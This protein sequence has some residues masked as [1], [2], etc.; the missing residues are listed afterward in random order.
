LTESFSA[1][2][3]I[4]RRPETVFVEGTGS[5]LTDSAGARYLGFVQGW[6]VNT[7]GHGHPAILDAIRH[8]AERLINP[9]QIFYNQPMIELA[10][11][12]VAHSAF[13]QVFFANSGAEANE[14]AVK[15]ARKWGSLHRGGAYKIITFE[16]AFHGRTLAMMSASGK[17]GWDSLFAPKVPGFTR[18]PFN[19]VRAVADA[20]D[21]DTVAV[22]LEPILGEAGVIPATASFVQD[23]RALTRE[24]D[25]LLIFDEV[26]T[27]M[28][29]TGTLFAYQQI[30]VEPDIMSLG[31]GI[32]G[33][34]PLSAL[35]TTEAVSCF[36]PG[37]QG[38]TYN[39]NPLVC[40]V[41]IAVLRTLLSPGFLS[42]VQARGQ[43]LRQGLADLATRHGLGAVRGH[44]LLL[45]LDTRGRDAVDIA[46]RAFRNGLLINA[47]RGDTLRFMPALSVAEEE[48]DRMLEILEATLDVRRSPLE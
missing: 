5:W 20:V 43:Y 23:L 40:A 16:N 14:G 31:K 39:G 38:G 7:L 34:V 41:G 42:G 9:S 12:L 21:A 18:V 46:T 13:D 30:G 25:L 4:T 22:M 47:P 36:E 3:P 32:G 27:G 1:L 45:G 19:D 28:G 6:A 17:P 10:G 35:L 2:M 24:K 15:L 11:L 29:R 48:I 8:Q 33:G 44:G 37:D 26:Q